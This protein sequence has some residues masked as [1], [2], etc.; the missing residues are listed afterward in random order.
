MPVEKNLSLQYELGV[1]DELV[2]ER[3]NPEQNPSVL[4]PECVDIAKK[5]KE[6]IS[7]KMVA[8]AY[9]FTKEKHT[10]TYIHH[11]QARISFLIEQLT[12]YQKHDF[13]KDSG[14]Y[15]QIVDQVLKQ[16]VS[17]NRFLADTFKDYFNY[18]AE[19]TVTFKHTASAY[20]TEQIKK[21]ED[22][23]E[24]NCPALLELALGAIKE[25]SANP[26]TKPITFRRLMYYDFM[27]KDIEPLILSDKIDHKSLI[28]T[29]IGLNFN[30]R[31]FMW[32]LTQ[33]IEHA[34]MPLETHSEKVDKLTWYLK[35]FNQAHVRSDIIFE[36][37]QEPIKERII[38]WILEEVGYLERNMR[39]EQG[40]INSGKEITDSEILF[41]TTLSVPQLAYFFKVMLES[42]ILK[43]R[44]IT[45]MLRF[46][47][48][49]SSST[50]TS[51]KIGYPSLRKNYYNN[52]TGA[53]QAVKDV[54][55]K[56]LNA[57]N[58]SL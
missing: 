53:K 52:E 25:F 41:E 35:Q 34:V 18:D 8:T 1:L 46:I 57:V 40:L 51:G 6:I 9:S 21:I 38:N 32:Y 58:K 27:L 49:H 37:N 23:F 16:I 48:E 44:N 3:I 5:Q 13:I 28:I 19:S 11:H 4:L 22:K 43:E 45:Q 36:R 10:I 39:V 7:K 14:E 50:N 17:I 54:I 29:L 30:S 20:F 26:L 31:Q 55:I 47:A 2:L 15:Q 42:K 56:M 12:N 24:G 33:E